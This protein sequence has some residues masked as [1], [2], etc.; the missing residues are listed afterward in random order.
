MINKMQGIP[1]I[2]F[3]DSGNSLGIVISK[4]TF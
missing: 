4:I 2:I 1:K 3:V